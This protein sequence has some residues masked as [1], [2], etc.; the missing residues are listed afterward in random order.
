[1]KINDIIQEGLRD[2]KD[3]PCWKGYHPVGTKKK[4]GRTVPN[5]VPESTEQDEVG[6]ST[7]TEE[8]TEKVGS[9]IKRVL[10][11]DLVYEPGYSKLYK[12][13]RRSKT[14]RIDYYNMKYVSVPRITNNLD[15]R[16]R[17]PLDKKLKAALVAAGYNV[18]HASV[19]SD[20]ISIQTRQPINVQEAGSPAQQAAIAIAMKK[21][22]KKPKNESIEVQEDASGYIP[23]NS[24]EAKDPRYVMSQTVDVKPGEDKRQAAK[25]GFKVQ[26]GGQAPL[27]RADGKA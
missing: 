4:D 15:G 9:I 24:K 21:K 27:L 8:P 5:C 23:K 25:F 12:D 17:G 7:I 3:N 10:G 2:P 19:W 6:E 14:E 26:A 13:T 1:M 16:Q 22:G 20:Q 11:K 18:I